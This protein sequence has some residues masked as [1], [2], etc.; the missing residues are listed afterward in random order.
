MRIARIPLRWRIAAA[1]VAVALIHL[2][3]RT[4]PPWYQARARFYPEAYAEAVSIL[5][6]EFGRETVAS[7]IVSIPRE[8]IVV[9]CEGVATALPEI[10]WD[11]EESP[12][13]ARSA[14]SPLLMLGPQNGIL[15]LFD[16]DE[17]SSWHLLTREDAC[18]LWAVMRYLSLTR[19]TL[20]ADDAV[21]RWKPEAACLFE[22]HVPPKRLD[23]VL[24]TAVFNSERIHTWP[25]AAAG[26]ARDAALL[27]LGERLYAQ[28]GKAL[29]NTQLHS[30]LAA[31]IERLFTRRYADCTCLDWAL[32]RFLELAGPEDMP[33]L[34]RLAQRS[35][36]MPAWMAKLPLIGSYFARRND[37]SSN[38]LSSIQGRIWALEALGNLDDEARFNALLR[39]AAGPQVMQRDEARRLLCADYRERWCECLADNYSPGSNRPHDLRDLDRAGRLTLA[40][41]GD[42]TSKFQPAALA[43]AYRMTRDASYLTRLEDVALNPTRLTARVFDSPFAP[44][45]PPPEE[46][47]APRR[48]DAEVARI[49]AEVASWRVDQPS[50]VVALSK[51]VLVNRDKPGLV[52]IENIARA[53]LRNATLETWSGIKPFVAQLGTLGEPSVLR[54]IADIAV[55]PAAVL[56][57]Q[58][59]AL[60][61]LYDLRLAA[62]SQLGAAPDDEVERKIEEFIEAAPYGGRDEHL[63][64][65]AAEALAA[66]RGAATLGVLE[67]YAERAARRMQDAHSADVALSVR[68]AIVEARLDGAHDRVEFLAGLP[69]EDAV[70]VT[71]EMLVRRCSRSDLQRALAD[72]RLSGMS[73]RVLDAMRFV[74]DDAR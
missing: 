30:L 6:E 55:Q 15:M 65:A 59:L 5:E 44:G 68:A 61:D 50:A 14:H 3:F 34:K 64:A 22:Y 13:A 32:R 57:A 58:V 73:G 26:Y 66:T 67:R 9:P 46:P 74:P 69:A 42:D 71:V 52:D 54:V 43:A 47:D 63:V 56:P 8:E 35:R 4:V 39:A 16:A 48:R 18:R 24:C 19:T 36:P 21:D 23:Q 1:V 11:L 12:P 53:T 40:I 27:R 25:S 60:R 31:Q 62:M 7:G 37:L 72:E 70:L 49:D 2:A 51:L 10:D 20:A 17:P 29:D 33:L 41:A 45:S 28:S 38:Y